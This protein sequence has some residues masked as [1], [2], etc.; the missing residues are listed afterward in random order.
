MANYDSN[1]V[2]IWLN[3]GLGSF[4][5]RV[6]VAVGDGPASLAMGDLDRDGDQDLVVTNLDSQTYPS[7][8]TTASARSRNCSERSHRRYRRV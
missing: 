3:N 5:T 8:V 7:C 1:N 6:Q 2:S 4:I